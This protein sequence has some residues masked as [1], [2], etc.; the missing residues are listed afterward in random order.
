MPSPEEQ[1]N[2]DPMDGLSGDPLN[3]ST[4]I[5]RVCSAYK[6]RWS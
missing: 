3:D 6:D 2:A 4:M 5:Y 1:T